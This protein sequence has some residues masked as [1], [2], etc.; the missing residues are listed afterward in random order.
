MRS[1]QG[2]L[3]AAGSSTGPASAASRG[4]AGQGAPTAV[5]RRRKEENQVDQKVHGDCKWH[6]LFLDAWREVK[7][8]FTHSGNNIR[9]RRE[10]VVMQ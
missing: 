8:S 7:I 9:G 3:P 5:R 1:C 2:H 6:L 4:R 10:R